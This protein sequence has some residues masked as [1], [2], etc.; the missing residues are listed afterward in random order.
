MLNMRNEITAALLS[1]GLIACGGESSD[2]GSRSSQASIDTK[3]SQDFH[4]LQ[5]APTLTTT[6]VSEGDSV[7]LNSK[8]SGH[9]LED[10]SVNL[11]FTAEK[12]GL[13]ILH[14]TSEV[15][16]VKLILTEP[17]T[18]IE[19]LT[20]LGATRDISGAERIITY[21]NLFLFPATEGLTYTI[22]IKST[23]DAAD[24]ILIL[25]DANREYLALG[26][27]EEYIVSETYIEDSTCALFDHRDLLIETTY[28][29]ETYHT[30][31]LMNWKAGYHSKGLH[32]N[33]VTGFN[34]AIGEFTLIF[35]DQDRHLSYGVDF[36]TGKVSS[37]ESTSNTNIDALEKTTEKCTVIHSM[38]GEIVL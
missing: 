27:P 12:S 7:E 34:N 33:K 3:F 19:V 36:E 30:F 32:H 29:S 35:E 4:G 8:V 20:T 6:D 22:E 5:A 2:S 16:D 26:N 15:N 11:T 1:L 9:V 25:T 10:S 23:E 13:M 37:N 28:S 31:S 14:S 21:R 24:F 17:D 18:A 38:T